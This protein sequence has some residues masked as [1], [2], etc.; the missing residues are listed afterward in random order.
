MQ[1]CPIP[2]LQGMSA[3]IF[4]ECL[5]RKTHRVH[6]TI[7]AQEKGEASYRFKKC[8]DTTTPRACSDLPLLAPS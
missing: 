1:A 6:G 7:Q 3:G 5:G 2:V 8:C 4:D